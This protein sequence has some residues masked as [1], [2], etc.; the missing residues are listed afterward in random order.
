M[1]ELFEAAFSGV[2]LI[3]TIL[4]LLIL[5]YWIFVILGALDMDF[6]DVEVDSGDVDLDVSLD[7]DADMDTEV[8]T[9]TDLGSV[10]FMNSILTFFNLGKIPFMVWLSFLFIPM[11]CISILMNHFLLNGSFLLSLVFLIP[12][13]I[14]SLMV[15]KVLTTPV[16]AMFN[17]LKHNAEDSF[18]YAGKVCTALMQA[19]HKKYGQAEIQHEGNTFRITILTK[20]DGVLLQKGETGLVI[21]FLED[22]KCYIVEPYK[23]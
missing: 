5:V 23:I 6:L 19:D 11:W 17:K 13:I 9:D 18:K 20:E 14:V 10:A 7:A 8:D 3:P 21:D 22:K 15:S 12:N 2:N 1:K 4:I 16:A